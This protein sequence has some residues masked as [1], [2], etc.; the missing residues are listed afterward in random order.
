M[1][2]AERARLIQRYRDGYGVVVEAL[3]GI[4][5]EELDRAPHGE[6]TPRQIVTTSPTRR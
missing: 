4:A 3:T 6:W 1:D 2:A 5:G